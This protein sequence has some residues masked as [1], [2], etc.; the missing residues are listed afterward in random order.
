MIK[1]KLPH[2][3]IKRILALTLVFTMIFHSTACGAIQKAEETKDQVI[4][5]VST[6]YESIDLEM[7][8]KGWNHAIDFASTTYATA[9]GSQYV[10]NVGNA[11]N[12]LKTSINSAYGSSLDVAQ[13]A[14]FAA[15]K[16][17]ADTFNIDAAARNSKESARVV[18]SYEHG[19]VDVTTSYGENASL[20]YYQT[21][22]SS[23]REQARTIIKDYG[24]YC[25]NSPNPMSLEE[26]L[27]KN[28]YDATKYDALLKSIYEGQTRIIPADQYDDA[29]AYLQKKINQIA[30]SGSGTTDT[31]TNV[32]QETLDNLK[33]R[34]EAPDGTCSTPAT[35]EEMQAIAELAQKGDF[36]PEDFGI[37]TAAIITPKYILKQAIGAGTFSAVIQAVCTIGPDIYSILS[38]AYKT[39]EFDDKALEETGIDGLLAG[40]EGFVE[41]A[42]SCALFTACKAGKLGPDLIDAS[43]N[44]IGA[45]TV[46]LVQAIRYG[47]SLSKGSISANDYSNLMAE[48]II[49]SIGVLGGEELIGLF[50]SVTPIAYLAGS[51]AGG[52]VAS[53]GYSMVKEIAL[54]IK[55][56]DGFAAIVPTKVLDSIS[57]A[58]DTIASLNIVDQITSFNDLTISTLTDEYIKIRKAF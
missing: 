13:E 52:M 12:N 6:W 41:G 43:P 31:Q 51:M 15:E 42:V 30:P 1:T 49:V 47:Y 57:I 36:K 2:H 5:Y 50:L 33:Q 54:E 23:A 39:G 58:K 18:G 24:K 17:V 34:L 53:I 35:Y 3:K 21:A 22:S 46:L 26:Y 55:D 16:W 29:V 48:N 9:M 44:V 20:K 25:N 32:Y 38:E 40:S 4:E 10:Q 37:T 56:G 8:Q 14:G 7:F 11:I 19:S 45:L 27:S 28:G